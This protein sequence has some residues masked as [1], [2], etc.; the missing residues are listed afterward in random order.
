MGYWS[1]KIEQWT[2][3]KNLK[4]SNK[5]YDQILVKMYDLNLR[6]RVPGIL[7]NL[8]EGGINT[9]NTFCFFSKYTLFTFTIKV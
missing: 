8:V 6:Y 3:F 5:C 9:W 7:N 1:G 2:P 4:I